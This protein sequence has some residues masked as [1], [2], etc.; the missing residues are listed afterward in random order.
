[1]KKQ[2]HPRTLISLFVAV[3]PYDFTSTPFSA[4]SYVSSLG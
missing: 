4:H 2:Y 1:M 3:V